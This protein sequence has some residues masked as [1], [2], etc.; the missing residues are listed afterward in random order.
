MAISMTTFGNTLSELQAG[1]NADKGLDYQRANAQDALNQQRLEAFLR[2]RGQQLETQARQS[3]TAAARTQRMAELLQQTQAN[4]ELA[5][6]DAASRLAVANAT[7]A[8]R[9][10]PANAELEALKFEQAQLLQ[11]GKQMSDARKAAVAERQKI[12]DAQG[13]TDF[14]EPNISFWNRRV[15]PRWTELNDLI[16]KIDVEAG[17]LGFAP[18]AD[19]GLTVGDTPVTPQVP[20]Q[21]NSFTPNQVVPLNLNQNSVPAMLQTP[22]VSTNRVIRVGPNQQLHY[23]Q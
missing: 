17:K 14:F 16:A 18:S 2:L 12:K 21:F 1:A 6:M 8:G 13:R 22:P 9:G 20:T 10:A 4:R 15:N 23:V 11:R 19:G 7:A 5:Q 3:D